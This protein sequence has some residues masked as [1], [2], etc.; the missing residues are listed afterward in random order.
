MGHFAARRRSLWVLKSVD[1]MAITA[2]E[3]TVNLK[4]RIRLTGRGSDGASGNNRIDNLTVEGISWPESA[5]AS[6]IHVQRHSRLC[7]TSSRRGGCAKLL[8]PG[9]LPCLRGVHILDGT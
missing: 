2:V 5:N 4:F 3:N 7:C 8:R 9:P 1:L 6:R